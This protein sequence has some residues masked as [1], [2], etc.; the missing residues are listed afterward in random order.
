[1]TE[2]DAT[3][4]EPR[5][6]SLDTLYIRTYGCQMNEADSETL[7]GQLATLGYGVTDSEDDAELLAAA[8]RALAR[9]VVQRER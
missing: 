6:R 8:L 4:P 2:T 7:L 9:M 3:M 1:M 5:A